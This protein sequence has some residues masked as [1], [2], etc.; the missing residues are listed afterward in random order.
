MDPDHFPDPV[1]TAPNMKTTFC[2]V[3]DRKFYA[4]TD[5][6]LDEIY[7]NHFAY[8]HPVGQDQGQI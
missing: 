6:E 1:P 2:G 5:V 4:R 3:C 8:T 7:K